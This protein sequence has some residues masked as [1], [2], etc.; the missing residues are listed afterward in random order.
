[1]Q[2]LYEAIF[3]KKI[4]NRNFRRKI[5]NLNILD[6][7]N[8][9]LEFSEDTKHFLSAINGISEEKD[10][11]PELEKEI[12]SYLKCKGKDEWDVTDVLPETP[13][14]EEDSAQ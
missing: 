8:N 11:S 3:D 6:M 12:L 14:L 10:L 7:Y 1:M 2:K 9:I 4:D 5:I 13:E